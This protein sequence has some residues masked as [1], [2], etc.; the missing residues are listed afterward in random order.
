MK[1]SEIISKIVILAIQSSF[2]SAY[3]DYNTESILYKEKLSICKKLYKTSFRENSKGFSD[4]LMY[5]FDKA[6]VYDIDHK[7][8]L[9]E[10]YVL[11][12]F[13]K[14]Q[15]KQENLPKIEYENLYNT[16]ISQKITNDLSN[17]LFV[18]ND[19]IIFEKNMKFTEEDLFFN[20]TIIKF[21]ENHNKN[22]Q[23]TSFLKKITVLPY[24]Y[25]YVSRKMQVFH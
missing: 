20:K 12:A 5:V 1:S 7:N 15:K 22:F 6:K 3:T 17:K 10:K 23:K 16:F 19:S 14:C 13:I 9:K 24:L 25:E 8:I 2:L 4:R 21:T 18:Y 11:D